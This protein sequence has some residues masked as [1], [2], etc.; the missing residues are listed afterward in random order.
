MK[1]FHVYYTL[2]KDSAFTGYG[3]KYVMC[4]VFPDV[5]STHDEIALQEQ[6]YQVAINNINEVTFDEYLENLS[7][8]A[9]KA[10]RLKYYES[11]L[12]DIKV[13]DDDEMLELGLDEERMEEI[14]YAVS[15][16]I[17]QAVDFDVLIMR[18]ISSVV[19]QFAERGNL[20][21]PQ[22]YFDRF[23]VSGDD[24]DKQTY[25]EMVMAYKVDL[26]KLADRF[27]TLIDTLDNQSTSIHEELYNALLKLS[28]LLP[29]M[30]N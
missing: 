8:D 1:F 18:F 25:D 10:A 12:G 11:V 28:K 16:S 30:W 6:P 19:K 24:T 7:D 14:Q 21:P 13:L 15:K 29:G 4:K 26:A 3:I 22:K 27:D 2:Y 17:E 23:E 20:T 9:R 5:T